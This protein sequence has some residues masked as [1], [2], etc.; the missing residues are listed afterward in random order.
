MKLLATIVGTATALMVVFF[1]EV[2]SC[3]PRYELLEATIINVQADPEWGF[4][5]EDKRTL[6]RFSDGL[7][8]YAP[9][10]LG[11]P[12]DIIKAS[13]RVGTESLFGWIGDESLLWRK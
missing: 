9:G 5:G 12:G 11:N 6:V 7:R 10:S 2:L 13:R 1:F 4:L 3:S 8:T